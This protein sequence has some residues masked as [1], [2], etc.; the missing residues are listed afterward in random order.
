LP[1]SSAV[2]AGGDRPIAVCPVD[3]LHGTEKAKPKPR[4]EPLSLA[5]VHIG[6][7]IGLAYSPD[8][9]ALCSW[10]GTMRLWDLSA[11]AGQAKPCEG[12]G[13]N[14][15]FFASHISWSP[16]GGRL[17]MAWGGTVTVR[18]ARTAEKLHEIEKPYS[19]TRHLT[20][21]PAGELFLS[22]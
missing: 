13:P 19:Y 9:R 4:G 20:Y 3:E 14:E 12:S 22:N 17:A 8:G 21:T 10:G 2:A 18:D 11:G 1:D 16:D 5:A 7:V 15:R 6:S